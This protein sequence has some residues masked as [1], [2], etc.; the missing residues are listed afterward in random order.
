MANWISTTQLAEE[1]AVTDRTIRYWAARGMIP[2]AIRV[3]RQFRFRLTVIEDWLNNSDI[4]LQQRDAHQWPRSI[5]EN[6]QQSTKHVSPSTE[7]LSAAQLAADVQS[8]LKKRQIASK[9]S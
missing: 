2:G 1:L 6:D 3:G 9:R 8:L 4:S 7:N 5:S